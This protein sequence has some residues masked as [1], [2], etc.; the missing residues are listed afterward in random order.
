[1]L[2]RAV[3]PA[4][5]RPRNAI[6]L[7]PRCQGSA[8][9]GVEAPAG[10]SASAEPRRA[11]QSGPHLPSS[12]R[13]FCRCSDPGALRLRTF[14]SSFH[15]PSPGEPV[16]GS[17]E[18]DVT[19]SFPPSGLPLPLTVARGCSGLDAA[20]LCPLSPPRLL[21]RNLVGLSWSGAEFTPQPGDPCPGGCQH[22]SF[23]TL[24]LRHCLP[25]WPGAA[26]L[27]G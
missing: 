3:L 20:G 1:M 4:R 16:I 19:T 25:S 9:A 27:S 11:G 8:A 24:A 26:S 17:A 14:H 18:P 23:L 7:G 22:S 2:S 13:S 21:C 5:S 6:A 10:I 12:F 15:A